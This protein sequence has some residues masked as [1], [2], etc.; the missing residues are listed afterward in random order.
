[1][2]EEYSGTLVLKKKNMCVLLRILFDIYVLIVV[3]I[4]LFNSTWI[5][6]AL[7]VCECNVFLM[8]SRVCYFNYVTVCLISQQIHYQSAGNFKQ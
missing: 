4:P 1:M 2:R 7:T 8:I 5:F 3:V 6:D